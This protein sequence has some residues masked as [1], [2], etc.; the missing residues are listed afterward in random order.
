MPPLALDISKPIV[1]NDNQDWKKEQ[2]LKR[3]LKKASKR[4]ENLR[5]LGNLAFKYICPHPI[6]KD[7]GRL[8]DGAEQLVHHVYVIPSL[9]MERVFLTLT[10]AD[11]H[12]VDYPDLNH[13]LAESNTIKEFSV[14]ISKLL[15]L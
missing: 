7:L 13:C 1:T 4:A 6:C 14:K 8:F 5:K 9:T 10:S 11:K 15:G 12:S 2:A 3:K